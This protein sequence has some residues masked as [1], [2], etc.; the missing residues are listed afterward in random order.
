MKTKT[1]IKKS[2]EKTD[3]LPKA[4]WNEKQSIDLGLDILSHYVRFGQRVGAPT[5]A[6]FCGCSEARIRQYQQQALKKVRQRLRAA[7]QMDAGQ[8]AAAVTKTI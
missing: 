1:M 6:A 3:A 5:I 2:I 8:F 4:H 7:F